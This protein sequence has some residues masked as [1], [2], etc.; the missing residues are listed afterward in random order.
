MRAGK[1]SFESVQS[2]GK[3]KLC[4]LENISLVFL[5]SQN[6]QQKQQETQSQH[7]NSIRLQLKSYILLRFFATQSSVFAKRLCA[8]L[9]VCVISAWLLK[10]GALKVSLLSV[11]NEE[12]TELDYGTANEA[13]KTKI[14]AHWTKHKQKDTNELK[15]YVRL[16][17]LKWFL[18]GK[19]IFSRDALNT[20]TESKLLNS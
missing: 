4:F 5:P 16:L 18:C 10:H 9:C 12:T 11:T 20:S 2:F 6:S 8:C 13:L 3:L 17:W 19:T 1:R 15:L 14:Q 7:H